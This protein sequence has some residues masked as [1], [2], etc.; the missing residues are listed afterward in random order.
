[1]V[2]CADRERI[3]VRLN[4]G[5]NRGRRCDDMWVFPHLSQFSPVKM[6]ATYFPRVQF[7]ITFPSMS[8]LSKYSFFFIFFN[9]DYYVLC[10]SHNRSDREVPIKTGQPQFGCW[11]FFSPLL[12]VCSIQFPG[13]GVLKVTWILL[14]DFLQDFG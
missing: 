13:R 6:L 12:H 8:W 9:Y 14:P 2:W 11:E 7:N 3:A 10:I 1:M 5:L 4:G